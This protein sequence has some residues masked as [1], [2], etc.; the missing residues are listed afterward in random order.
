M[1]DPS[2]DFL[3]DDERNYLAGVQTQDDRLFQ[4]GDN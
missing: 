2:Q 1:T 4:K 3:R